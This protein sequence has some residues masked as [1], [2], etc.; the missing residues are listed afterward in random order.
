MLA[1]LIAIHILQNQSLQ[2]PPIPE[3]HFALRWGVH[4]YRIG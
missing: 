3:P 4:P 2:T 1:T